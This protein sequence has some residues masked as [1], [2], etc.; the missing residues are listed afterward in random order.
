MMSGAPGSRG[1]PER[2][3][4]YAAQH[5]MKTMKDDSWQ[6]NV[7]RTAPA[8]TSNVATPVETYGCFSLHDY[9]RPRLD[10]QKSDL[11]KIGN[12]KLK[13]AEMKWTQDKLEHDKEEMAPRTEAQQLEA[14]S[15]SLPQ[16]SDERR[17]SLEVQPPVVEDK[18]DA[19]Q[20]R[21]WWQFW[22]WNP[23]L[24]RYTNGKKKNPDRKEEG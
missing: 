8:E 12:G 2:W 9:F 16:G 19:D 10:E 15:E 7:A 22:K 4:H 17:A 20:T 21:R 6:T 24:G 18:A 5:M 23:D 11:K 14:G 1:V 3:P 13:W